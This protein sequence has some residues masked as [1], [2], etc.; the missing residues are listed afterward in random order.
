MVMSCNIY[1]C[2]ISYFVI[3]VTKRQVKPPIICKTHTKRPGLAGTGPLSGQRHASRFRKEAVRRAPLSPY[4]PATGAVADPDRRRPWYLA[5]L[6]Q[7]DRAQSAPGD[8]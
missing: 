7:P 2:S 3:L 6:H 5:L 4:P 8:G 1:T